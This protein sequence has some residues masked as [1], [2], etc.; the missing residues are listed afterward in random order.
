VDFLTLFVK[1]SIFL[2]YTFSPYFTSKTKKKP[3]ITKEM[4]TSEKGGLTII[5]RAGINNIENKGIKDNHLPIPTLIET[6]LLR[7][8]AT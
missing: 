3:L 1:F 7:S 6:G 8:M 5:I 4:N 2:T